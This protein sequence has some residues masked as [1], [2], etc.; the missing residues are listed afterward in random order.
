MRVGRSTGKGAERIYFS[1]D[2]KGSVDGVKLRGQNTLESNLPWH[3]MLV[4]L[5]W[6]VTHVMDIVAHWVSVW[7]F[8]VMTI[9]FQHVQKHELWRGLLHSPSYYIE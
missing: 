4:A 5:P 7:Y 8:F 2:V 6:I 3:A 1:A 9:P